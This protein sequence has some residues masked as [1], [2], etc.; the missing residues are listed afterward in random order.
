MLLQ[1]DSRQRTAD[2]GFGALL[3]SAVCCLLSIASCTPPPPPHLQLQ[4]AGQVID[5]QLREIVVT[6][7]NDGAT[8]LYAFPVEID[9]PANLTI[10]RESHEAG[11]ELRSTRDGVYRYTVAQLA[12][13]DH[14]TARFPFRREAS[15]A[16][17]GADIRVMAANIEARRALSE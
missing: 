2:S 12:P 10:I 8:P 16:L 13:N 6:V 15:A 7:I 4:I 17:A 9:L 1:S 11:L 3:L 14:V 5:R